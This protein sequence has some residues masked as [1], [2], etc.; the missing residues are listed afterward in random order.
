MGWGLE[1]LREEL[2]PEEEKPKEE[3]AGSS[4]IVERKNFRRELKD[5]EQGCTGSDRLKETAGDS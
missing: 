4:S 5:R 1:K 2:S 3:M